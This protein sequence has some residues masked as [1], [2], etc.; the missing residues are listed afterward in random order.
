MFPPRAA[1]ARYSMRRRLLLAFG[2]LLVVF[3]G[4]AGYVL[5]RAFKQSVA[6]AVA[7]RL[8]LQ[9][10]ALVGVAEPERGGFFVPDL[11]EARFSQIDSG[12]Y[13]FIYDAAGRELWRSASA[14]NLVADTAGLA[15]M[16]Q[17]PGQTTYG[18]LAIEQ[19]V[20]AW[21]AYRTYW[22]SLDETF[23]FVVLETNAP[24]VA[25]IVAFRTNLYVWFGALTVLLSIAQYLLL[26]WGLQPLQQLAR[27]VSAIET[28]AQNELQRHYPEELEGVTQNL[29]LLIKSERERQ[30]RF[31]TTLG[32]LAHSLKTPLAVLSTA[33]QEAQGAAALSE[34][35]RQDMHEQLQRMDQIVSYQL[36]RAVKGSQLPMARPVSVLPLIEKLAAALQK[37]YRDKQMQVELRCAA[38]V[39]FFGEESDLLEVAGNLLDNAFKYG[40]R[41]VRVTATQQGKALLL[42]IDDDGPGVAANDR[43]FVLQRGARADTAKSGQGIGLAVVVEI[44]STY[45]GATDIQTSEWGGAAVSVRFG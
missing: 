19:D 10:Y 2:M 6:A 18:E 26:R 13:G 25:E 24:S 14:L 32:D 45:G 36:K 3:L 37:V 34:D 40:H 17:L 42:T 9:V 20:L 28:G 22:Q 29:N 38:G 23:F 15:D 12:L 1:D 7:E 16:Q 27:E 4:V 5:D 21:A 43:H 41:R 39:Q 30:N 31:R 8:Q 33:L 35:Q 44:V 11:E